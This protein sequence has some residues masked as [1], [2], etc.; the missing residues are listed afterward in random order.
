MMRQRASES[1][2]L[3]VMKVI[4]RMN[5]RSPRRKA[6]FGHTRPGEKKLSANALDKLDGCPYNL[7]SFGRQAF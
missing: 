6:E 2:F 7:A 1:N 5:G 4:T 3:L